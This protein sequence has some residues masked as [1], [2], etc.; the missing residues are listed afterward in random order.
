MPVENHP[1]EAIQTALAR[2]LETFPRLETQRL[3]LRQMQ[4]ADAE[5]VQ[6]LFGDPAV[7][8][9]YDLD[10]LTDVQQ[11]LALVRRQNERFE[12]RE[13]VA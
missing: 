12:R 10:T 9:Y 5:A 3:V 11:A 2:A 7:T 8:R 13:G 4:P 6:H 1:G